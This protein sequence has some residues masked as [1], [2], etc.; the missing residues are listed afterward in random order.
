MSLPRPFALNSQLFNPTLYSHLLK[1]W[2]A[3]LPTSASNP[4]KEQV[5]RWFGVGASQ[6]AKSAFD[7]ECTSTALPALQSIAADKYPL[8]PFKDAEQDRQN[9]THIA[10]P[11]I[12]Q[13][14]SQKSDLSNDEAALG[15]VLLLDQMPRNIFRSQQDIIYTHYD[16]ISRAVAYAI[17][18]RDL[19]SSDRYR[20]SPPWQAW[21]YL[22]LMHSEALS[23]H[24]FLQRKVETMQARMRQK[25]DPAAAEYADN[26]LNF[27]KKHYDILQRFGRYPHRN[28]ALGR[29]STK[30][31]REY[32]E[33][34]GDTFGTS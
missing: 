24:L 16:R 3:D 8:P 18:S 23:D 34:G 12:G 7:G 22:P 26:L 32:L 6:E 30:E 31:E 17:Y 15:L 1:L 5:S 33:G 21:F 10:Q 13:F 20:D 4:T 27:E 25:D 9:Y 14:T 29:E 11:F 2:F 28:R 19:D